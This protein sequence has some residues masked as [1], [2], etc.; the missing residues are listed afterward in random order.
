MTLAGDVLA[1]AAH[2]TALPVDLLAQA[3]SDEFPDPDLP[4]TA[5]RGSLIVAANWVADELLNDADT[6]AHGGTIEDTSQLVDLPPQFEPHYTAGFARQ[7]LVAFLDMSARLTAAQWTAPSCVAQELGVRLLL[8]QATGVADLAGIALPPD[9]P[10]TLAELPARGHR[11]RIPLRPRPRRIRGRPGL[12]PT[13]H[14]FH[15]RPGLVHPLPRPPTPA[16]LPH[17]IASPCPMPAALAT[18][19]AGPL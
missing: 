7:F 10:D 4:L 14:G 6:L 15:A 12:R 13:R 2:C 11:P 3:Y 8:A 17:L 9:W 19:R 1:A 5:I 18:N 16:P